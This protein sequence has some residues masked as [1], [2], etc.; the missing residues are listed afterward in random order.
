MA[1]R[2]PAKVANP[3]GAPA[4]GKSQ[5][6]FDPAA[7]ARAES[8]GL[9]ARAVVEGYRVG[10]HRSPFQGFALEFAQHRE[11]T[12]GDDLRHID[13]KVLGRTDRYFIKQYEQ[14]TNLV[15]W[16]LV[17]CSRSMA[18]GSDQVTKLDYAKALAATLAH[19][20]LLH[21]DAVAMMMFDEQV[22]DSAARSD[23]IGK[24]HDIMRQLA[25][26]EPTGQTA[27][28]QGME[29]I[30]ASFRARGIVVLISDFLDDEDEIEAGIQQ[31][32]FQRHEVILFHVL[33]REE[34]EFSFRGRFRFEGLEEDRKVQIDPADYRKDYLAAM[35]KFTDRLRGIAE[36][37][38]SHY[39]LVDTSHSLEECLGRYLYFRQQVSRR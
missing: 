9:L 5:P 16:M 21:K 20:V 10:E 18:Y 34:I 19:A 35:K 29:R 2:S 30:A 13:W 8:L 26:L 36:R 1:K 24:I 11:Y 15:A 3:S 6:I 22:R 32:R 28:R 33:D 23:S 7:L 25:A 39:I 12:S 38:D 14:D 37:A 27:L 31:L 4:A 17:D